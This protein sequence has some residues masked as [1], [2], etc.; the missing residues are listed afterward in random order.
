MVLAATRAATARVIL[1]VMAPL[2]GT[3]GAVSSPFVRSCGGV[4]VADMQ[5]PDVEESSGEE[6]YVEEPS[7]SQ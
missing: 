1:V 3:T 6:L 5:E 4:S 7:Y 2:A